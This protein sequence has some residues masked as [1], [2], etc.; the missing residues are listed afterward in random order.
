MFVD[1]LPRDVRLRAADRD[2]VD[3]RLELSQVDVNEPMSPEVF[4]V[5]I[6]QGF[7]P[8]TVEEL[9]RSAPFGAGAPE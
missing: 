7:A 2:R 1:G 8:M 5:A 3:L 9:R 4:Q 6:P